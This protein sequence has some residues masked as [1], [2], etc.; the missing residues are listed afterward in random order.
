[1]RLLIPWQQRQDKIHIVDELSIDTLR[2]EFKTSTMGHRSNDRAK[3]PFQFTD[4]QAALSFNLKRAFPLS[5]AGSFDRLLDAID[6]ADEGTGR[7]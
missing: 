2:S 7:G 5:Y 3:R 1:M 6:V 4:E